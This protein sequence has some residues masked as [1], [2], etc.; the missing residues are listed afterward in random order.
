MCDGG[1][2]AMQLFS[3]QPF[4]A[5]VSDHDMPEVNGNELLARIRE[6]A[7]STVRVMLTGHPTLE[8]AIEA[9]NEGQIHRFLTKPCN[10]LE[11]ASSLRQGL[12]QKQLLENARRLLIEL[13][14]KTRLLDEFEA[15]K[16]GRQH[17]P[18]DE[19][20]AIVL[21]AVPSDLDALLEEIDRAT[22]SAR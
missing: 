17:L 8:K 10:P 14:R 20:G 2:E 11:L 4:D 1:R 15:L 7:P 13:Q 6:I 3:E 16:Q 9:V 22:G 19:H 18:R 5:V 21:D 12:K